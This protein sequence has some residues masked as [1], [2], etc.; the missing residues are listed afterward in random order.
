MIRDFSYGIL[1]VRKE[2]AGWQVLLVQPHE[3]WWGFPKGHAEAG[4]TPEIAAER[5]LL[6]ETGLKVVKFLP[7]TPLEENYK[8]WFKGQQYDKTV[9]YFVA[10]VTGEIRVQPEEIKSAR[11]VDLDQAEDLVTYPESKAICRHL[12]SLLLID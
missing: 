2:S 5:E 9:R 11:W 3:G 1:S 6:E 12:V 8:F 4:E 7:F 10:E